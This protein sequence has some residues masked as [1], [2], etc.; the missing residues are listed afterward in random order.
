[1]SGR[2]SA[3][4]RP[5][6]LVLDEEV[7][8]PPHTGKRLRTLNLLS[9]LAREFEIELA[10]HGGGIGVDGVQ[11]MARRGIR[12]HASTSRVPDKFGVKFPFRIL[13]SLCRGW[14]YSAYSHFRRGYRRLVTQLIAERHPDLVHCEWT[15][16]ALYADNL[17]VPVCV[18]AHNVEFAIWQ[19]MADA[20]GRLF[21]KS[22]NLVQSGLMRRFESR[23][24]KTFPFATTVSEGDAAV[25]RKLGCR[26]VVVV[27]NGVDTEAYSPLPEDLEQP[28]TLVFTGSLDWRPNQDAI[29]WF[30]TEV[31][32]LLRRLGPYRFC[33]VGRA[34]PRWLLDRSA[35]PSEIEVVGT[36]DDVRPWIAR[37]AVYVVPLR[38]GG[39]SRLKILEALAMRRAVVST[40]IGAEGLEIVPNEH[41]IAAEE[42]PAFASAIRRLLDDPARR[43]SLGRAGRAKIEELYPWDAIAARQ[44]ELWHRLVSNSGSA[45][46]DGSWAQVHSRDADSSAGEEV[47]VGSAAEIQ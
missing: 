46:P 12:V 36:V 30:I 18:A 13:A 25:I 27:P 43:A 6:V 22:F 37:A 16:Y 3:R 5:R 35:I 1:M 26:H 11:E 38:V 14:P 8:W 29:R 33:V 4:R 39:G 32:P 21:H 20:D 34:P 17:R 41:F 10:V 40:S 2:P 42:P 15:P 24:Y 44:A 7:P 31:H 28:G 47:R 23:I 19:R 45:I 9:S